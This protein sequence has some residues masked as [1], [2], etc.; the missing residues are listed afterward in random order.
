M[1]EHGNFQGKKK[2]S[3]LNPFLDTPKQHLKLL[4]CQKLSAEAAEA[5]SG[6]ELLRNSQGNSFFSENVDINFCKAH[7]K[8]GAGTTSKG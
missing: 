7:K 4:C 6:A 5:P 3:L 1:P 2:S 8:R